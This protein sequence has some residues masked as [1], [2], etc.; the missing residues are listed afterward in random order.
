MLFF[1][2]L[3]TVFVTLIVFTIGFVAA[4]LWFDF[5]TKKAPPKIITPVKTEP[6]QEPTE[7]PIIHK[8]IEVWQVGND[9]EILDSSYQM[10][11]NLQ[12]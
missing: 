2:Y 10:A 5:S 8:K 1:H 3:L 9:T 7:L 11:W 4:V 6:I 12:E